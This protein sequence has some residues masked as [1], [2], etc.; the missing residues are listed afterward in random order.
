MISNF[1]FKVTYRMYICINL[2]FNIN[3]IKIQMSTI[4]AFRKVQVSFYTPT[5]TKNIFKMLLIKII[6]I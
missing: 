5:Q 3:R 6:I 2:H 4:I 1:C